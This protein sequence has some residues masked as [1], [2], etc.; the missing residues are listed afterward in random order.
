VQTTTPAIGHATLRAATCADAAAV[1]AVVQRAFAEY[2]GRLDPPS[3]AFRETEERLRTQ[4]QKEHCILAVAGAEI[5]GCVFAVPRAATGAAGQ[6]MYLYRLAVVPEARQAGIG[7]ALVAAV[8]AHAHA[9]G[10]DWVALGVRIALPGNRRYYEALGY[11]VVAF[12]AHWGSTY[13]TYMTLRKRVG[14]PV[15]R[16]VTVQP[17]SPRW[18]EEAARAA[19]EVAGVL[20]DDLIS[21]QHIGSTA[22]RGLAAKPVIDL[23]AV[24]RD[25][26][27]LD[28]RDE[29]MLAAGWQPWG[30]HGIPG[31]RFYRKGDE[32]L[33]THHL[34]AYAEGHPAIA[35]HR[36]LVAYLNS[37]PS[38]AAR[39]AERKQEAARLH[40]WDIEGY[41]EAKSDLVRTLNARALAWVRNQGAQGPAT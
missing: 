18:A 35:E 13:S 2:R 15:A 39:Y 11:R 6:E 4:I 26:P 7:A 19:A 31:R 16:A 9:A 33:H 23:M 22:V 38:E 40:P 32:R 14:T 3:G 21:V 34:H 12:G 5:V 8:E 30:E 37:Q 28:G 27:R 24:V 41:I 1:L 25:V 17:W 36:A 20:D 29:Q 10:F